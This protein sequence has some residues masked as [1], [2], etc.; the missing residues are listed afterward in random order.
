MSALSVEGGRSEGRRR[1]AKSVGVDVSATAL[2]L[3]G[4]G[5]SVVQ[6]WWERRADGERWWGRVGGF[7][8]RRRRRSH[9]RM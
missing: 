1:E 9:V 6:F 3:W 4:C 7:V 2:A 5:K 8:R